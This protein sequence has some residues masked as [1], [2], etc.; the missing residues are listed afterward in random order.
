MLRPSGD[1]VVR[2]CLMMY[3]KQEGESLLACGS[4]PAGREGKRVFARSPRLGQ[5]DTGRMELSLTRIFFCSPKRPIQ[6]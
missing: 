2:R 5:E 4:V 1:C 3:K 6:P